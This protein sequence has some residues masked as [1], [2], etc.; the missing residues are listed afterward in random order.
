MGA[1]EGAPAAAPAFFSWMSFAA[2]WAPLAIVLE[3]FFGWGGRLGGMRGSLFCPP[4][5]LPHQV[6]HS[7]MRG[8][9][10]PPPGGRWS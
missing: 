5:Q 8:A 10:S 6:L 2:P 7:P 9:P 1:W 3:L 4:S